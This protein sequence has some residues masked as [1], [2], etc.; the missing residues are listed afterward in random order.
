MVRALAVVG[1]L[2]LVITLAVVGPAALSALTVA[3][4]LSALTV[5]AALAQSL[6]VVGAGV[7]SLALALAVTG[8]VTGVALTARRGRAAGALRAVAPVSLPAT[9]G[10]RGRRDRIARDDG[11]R[12][13]GHVAA[14]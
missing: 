12:L 4:T 5:A 8:A 9:L 3:A 1:A 6:A 2:S 7:M 11:S 13:L 14:V 10:R